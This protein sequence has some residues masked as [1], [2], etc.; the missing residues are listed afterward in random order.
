MKKTAGVLDRN[1]E[2]NS[3]VKK[4]IRYSYKSRQANPEHIYD[5][6]T[7][8]IFRITVFF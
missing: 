8:N 3:K 2:N 5:A 4:Q 1:H 7:W 6:M